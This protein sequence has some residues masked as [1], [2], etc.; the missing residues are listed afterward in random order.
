MCGKLRHV[1][2]VNVQSKGKKEEVLRTAKL[3]LPRKILE[4]VFGEFTP[5]TVI[6]P[7]ESVVGFVIREVPSVDEENEEEVYVEGGD[8]EE[9]DDAV[10]EEM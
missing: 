3:S 10:A 6:V 2:R 8:G 1:V 7:G 5:M 4:W 9:C